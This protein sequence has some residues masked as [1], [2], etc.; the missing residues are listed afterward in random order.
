MEITHND[1]K[2]NMYKNMFIVAYFVYV[3]KK[4]ARG[5]HVDVIQFSGSQC[6]EQ[7]TSIYKINNLILTSR[8]TVM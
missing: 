8:H 1:R 2:T 5:V 6:T 4:M 7:Y 3:R